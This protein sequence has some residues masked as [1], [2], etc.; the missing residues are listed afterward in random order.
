MR[1]MEPDG[2]IF[3]GTPE[4]C[5]RYR[6]LCAPP[7]PERTTAGGLGVFLRHPTSAGEQL[8]GAPRLSPVWDQLL[9]GTFSWESRVSMTEVSYEEHA[10]DRALALLAFGGE[11]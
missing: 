1:M 8:L 7:L 6:R 5:A 11:S 4:E 10:T 9:D 2:T 3:E